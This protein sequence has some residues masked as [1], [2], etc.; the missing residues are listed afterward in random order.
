[1]VERVVHE[2]DAIVRVVRFPG[3]QQTIKGKREVKQS[4]RTALQKYQLHK[5][6]DL[7]D[8]AYGYI[9]EYY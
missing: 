4:L 3:W 8:K 7:F 5:E 6:Q 2:I 9:E 1:M